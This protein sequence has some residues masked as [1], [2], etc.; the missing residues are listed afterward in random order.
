[1]PM[2]GR[3]NT[4]NVDISIIVP[5]KKRK[6]CEYAAC[7]TVTAHKEENGTSYYYKADDYYR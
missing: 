2:E 7:L 3:L 4:S 5:G 6:D 1:M